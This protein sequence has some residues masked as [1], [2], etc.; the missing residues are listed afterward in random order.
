MKRV[1]LE[2]KILSFCG[3]QKSYP[4]IIM[5]KLKSC[6]FLCFKVYFSLNHHAI[7]L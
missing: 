7:F 4:V 6:L 1:D 3:K 5:A 2:E